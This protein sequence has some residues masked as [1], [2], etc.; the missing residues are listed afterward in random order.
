M[1][2]VRCNGNERT[3]FD[4]PQGRFNRSNCIHA[5]DL[6]IVCNAPDLG[7][8]EKVNISKRSLCRVV[9]R[10][11][12]PPTQTQTVLPGRTKLKPLYHLNL[13]VMYLLCRCIPKFP[14]THK[15]KTIMIIIAPSTPSPLPLRVIPSSQNNV[16]KTMKY[17]QSRLDLC[18][19]LI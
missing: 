3:I 14:T 10:P 8:R 19:Y 13:P 6:G 4:C 15:K 2:D 11:H 9:A 18:Y 16:V 7:V 1:W 12:P 17:L 5:H